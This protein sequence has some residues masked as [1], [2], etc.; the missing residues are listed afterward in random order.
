MRKLDEHTDINL[1]EERVGTI[2]PDR[3]THECDPSTRVTMEGEG[4]D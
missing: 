1:Y 4:R 3:I 2:V